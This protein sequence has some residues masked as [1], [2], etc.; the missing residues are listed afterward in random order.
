LTRGQPLLISGFWRHPRLCEVVLYQTARPASNASVLE[1]AAMAI[2]IEHTPDVVRAPG[3][4]SCMAGEGPSNRRD[5]HVMMWS[6]A[7]CMRSATLLHYQD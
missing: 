7:G 1:I 6:V 5:Q 2:N 4:R 3:I